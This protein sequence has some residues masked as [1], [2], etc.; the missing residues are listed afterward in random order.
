[1]QMARLTASSSTYQVIGQGLEVDRMCSDIVSNYGE[2]INI[3]RQNVDYRVSICEYYQSVFLLKTV[4]I[5]LSV[6][7]PCMEIQN[8]AYVCSLLWG[9]YKHNTFFLPLRFYQSV[10]SIQFCSHHNGWTFDQCKLI[11]IMLFTSKVISINGMHHNLGSQI[12]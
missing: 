1:M 10:R 11:M 9:G 5:S 6:L 8:W 2:L 12:S 7:K 3:K 4:M